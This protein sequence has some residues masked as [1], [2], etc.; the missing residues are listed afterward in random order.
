ME[1]VKSLKGWKRFEKNLEKKKKVKKQKRQ[2]PYLIPNT[3]KRD[4]PKLTLQTFRNGDRYK[5]NQYDSKFDPRH[6]Q[7]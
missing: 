4:E 3:D 7:T 5:T 2:R 1:N 6:H